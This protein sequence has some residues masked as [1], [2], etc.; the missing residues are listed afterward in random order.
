MALPR[1]PSQY[2]GTLPTLI[3]SSL[4]QPPPA[5]I[6]V[7]VIPYRSSKIWP[8]PIAGSASQIFLIDSGRGADP[9]TCSL[10][11]DEASVAA[12]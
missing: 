11:L 4:S 9:D 8:P 7:S 3:L 6:P 12:R 1:Q 5:M 2:E 10:S